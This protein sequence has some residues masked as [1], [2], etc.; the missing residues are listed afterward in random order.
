M[1]EQRVDMY[2]EKVHNKKLHA[3]ISHFYQ[4]SQ[5]HLKLAYLMRDHRQFKCCF[6]LCDWSFNAVLKA[7][8]IHEDRTPFVPSELTMNEIL[9]LVHRNETGEGLD[10]AL[11]IGTM[12]HLSCLEVDL[13]QQLLDIHHVDQLLEKTEDLVHQ[14]AENL[15]IEQW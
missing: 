1:L 5:Y 7:L 9:R 13:D 2:F 15:N 14:L 11:F 10:I 6:I 12:Q 8:Y 3:L 4:T